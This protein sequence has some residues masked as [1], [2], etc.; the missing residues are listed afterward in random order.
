MSHTRSKI[1]NPIPIRFRIY[2]SLFVIVIIG[3]VIGM[4][5]IEQL[6]PVDALYFVIVTLATVG[7]GDIHP[8]S[9]TGKLL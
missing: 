3:G 5:V 6:S 1:K 7:Y 8:L 2:L 9:P 4:M